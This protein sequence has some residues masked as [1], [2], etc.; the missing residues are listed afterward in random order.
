MIPAICGAVMAGFQVFVLWKARDLLARHARLVAGAFRGPASDPVERAILGPLVLSIH[1]LLAVFLAAPG[2][3][4]IFCIYQ[5]LHPDP[6]AARADDDAVTFRYEWPF[7]ERRVAYVDI[8]NMALS[9]WRSR[10]PGPGVRLDVV[11]RDQTFDIR[12]T[13]RAAE[14]ER[15][16]E[17]I[18]Q[19]APPAPP[20]ES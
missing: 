5:S 20:S 19:K 7:R 4:G 16:Y 12:A 15:L 9:P 6:V 8:R 13:G 10:R 3:L 17:V 11:T 1:L 18:R 2:G 14:V